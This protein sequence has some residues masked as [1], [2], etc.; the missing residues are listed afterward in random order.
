MADVPEVPERSPSE[1][2]ADMVYMKKYVR[3]F[4]KQER[5]FH[6]KLFG[7]KDGRIPPKT[8]D[9]REGDSIVDASFERMAKEHPEK[10]VE[11]NLIYMMGHYPELVARKY[12]HL[13]PR[14][15][16]HNLDKNLEDYGVEDTRNLPHGIFKRSTK[17]DSWGV[18]AYGDFTKGEQFRVLVTPWKKPPEV[19]TVACVWTGADF[20]TG[21]NI[22]ICKI[23]K[24]MSRDRY[25]GSSEKDDP[26]REPTVKDYVYIPKEEREKNAKNAGNAK[27]TESNSKSLSEEDQKKLFEFVEL[28]R[29]EKEI[30]SHMGISIPEFRKLSLELIETKETTTRNRSG[31]V[32]GLQS[33]TSESF[34]GRRKGRTKEKIGS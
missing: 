27:K 8:E 5:E 28:P 29:T 34:A 2:Q 18:L 7:D 32:F 23:V 10:M 14:E 31:K 9:E 17:D 19:V 21:D 6:R 26:S 1:I 24:R 22:G 15:D 25:A 30:S 11:K 33:S 16:R 13:I 12:S 3:D 4:L 20:K